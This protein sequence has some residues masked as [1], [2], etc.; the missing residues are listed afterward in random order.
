[1]NLETKLIEVSAAI[2][3]PSSSP[4]DNSAAPIT[5]PSV[6]LIA[7]GSRHGGGSK[8]T[9]RG[10]SSKIASRSLGVARRMT[11]AGSSGCT[12][13]HLQIPALMQCIS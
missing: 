8:T 11:T 13:L 4:E 10:T 1:M 2:P 7:E 9:S 5:L 3:R 12:R 6:T